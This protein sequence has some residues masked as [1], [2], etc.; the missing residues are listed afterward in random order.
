MMTGVE[1]SLAST[2]R[3]LCTVGGSVRRS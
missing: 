2:P 1:S 3:N